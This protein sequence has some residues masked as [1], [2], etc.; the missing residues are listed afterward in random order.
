M[1]FLESTWP[2][3]GIIILLLLFIGETCNRKKESEAE[4]LKRRQNEAAL[5]DSLQYERL[6]SGELEA[7]KAVYVASIEELKVVNKGLWNDING[8]KGEILS[9]NRTILSL[10]QDRDQLQKA[11]DSLMSIIGPIQQINDSTWMAPWTL[12]YKWDETNWD[13]FKGETYI[14][15][16]GEPFSLW[17]RSTSLVERESMINLTFGHRVENGLLR[18][19][20][21]SKYP[22]L[23]P[24]SLEGVLI[25]PREISWFDPFGERSGWFPNRLNKWTVSFGVTTGWDIFRG[26][27]AVVVGPTFGWVIFQK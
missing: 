1:K 3:I 17:H 14:G 12:Y 23:T 11:L 6:K 27:P 18:V 24:T 4:A 10:R 19:F 9:L 2:W 7:S 25:D 13:R 20:V 21:Q 8:Q 15:L 22:G 16:T 5:R 26:K